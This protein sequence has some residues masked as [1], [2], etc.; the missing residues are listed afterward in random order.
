MR[1]NFKT[2]FLFYTVI[3]FT[4]FS[5]KKDEKLDSPNING[6]RTVCL[7]EQEVE[8]SI[9]L[10]APVDYVL[11][12]VP[13]GTEIVSGQGSNKILVN[14]GGVAGK[15]T[16]QIQD[17][18]QSGIQN[19]IDVNFDCQTNKICRIKDF[20]GA[21]RKRAFAFQIGNKGYIG[22]GYGVNSNTGQTED[23]KD[24]WELDTETQTWSQKAN[25]N[26]FSGYLYSY[27][28]QFTIQNDFYIFSTNSSG[29][30]YNLISYSAL[31]NS[32]T[33]KGSVGNLDNYGAACFS[34]NGK[35]YV[36]CGDENNFSTPP[37][38][39]S[40]YLNTVFEYEPTTDTW[41]QKNNFPGSTR[42]LSKG[43]SIGGNGYITGGYDFI[44]SPPNGNYVYYKDVWKYE[45]ST[46]TWT[47]QAD[48]PSYFDNSLYQISTI[49]N[50]AFLTYIDY[51]GY[52]KILRFN[53]TE[54]NTWVT[55]KEAT[56]N[57]NYNFSMF[58]AGT[59]LY[60]GLGE[61]I[62]SNLGNPNSSRIYKFCTE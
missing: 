58:S 30:A 55:L 61:N 59:Q 43:F 32:W 53:P 39:S 47:A 16:A 36:C 44:N 1:L 14:F 11:W 54:N 48:L 34:V 31:N 46:D 56:V 24:L 9:N 52:L 40:Y 27:F 60:F 12:S 62:Q 15:I 7:G 25:F 13:Q 22:G 57:F 18:N 4:L 28:N 38:G 45:S 37:I 42:I 20:P 29:I 26:G 2:G 19:A 50:N 33:T 8:Y 41:I 6:P 51:Y 5:C 17:K 35:G 23:Y 21:A 49:S 3:L 10:N